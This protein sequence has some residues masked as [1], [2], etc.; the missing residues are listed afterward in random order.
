MKKILFLTLLLFSL[1]FGCSK[2]REA[3]DSSNVSVKTTPPDPVPVVK[4][5]PVSFQT[6][7]FDA[8]K[9]SEGKSF[10]LRFV[11]PEEWEMEYIPS[12]RAINLFVKQGAS[13]TRDRAR[14]IIRVH[15]SSEASSVPRG[16]NV[17]TSEQLVLGKG[18]YAARKNTLESIDK[19]VLA[20]EE[21]KWLSQTHQLTE[22][23]P[24]ESRKPFYSVAV[25]PDVDRNIVNVMLSSLEI[26][27]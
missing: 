13:S 23:R 26:L 10:P 22:I 8:G 14:I 6:R 20:A 5:E 15:A 4:I 2:S 1:G 9:R 16:R 21:P 19:K 18:K 7:T 12:L 11:Y 17:V 27:K 24:K 3:T 25:H